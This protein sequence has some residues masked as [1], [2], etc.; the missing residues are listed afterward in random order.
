MT[1]APVP[2]PLWRVAGPLPRTVEVVAACGRCG[3]P[4]ADLRRRPKDDLLAL[5]RSTGTVA[6]QVS[7][8]AIWLLALSRR[9][10]A[11]YGLAAAAA[12][13]VTLI[14]A[15]RFGWRWRQSRST[16]RLTCEGASGGAHLAAAGRCGVGGAAVATNGATSIRADAVASAA[17]RWLLLA[18]L[19]APRA[20]PLSPRCP[21]SLAVP[22]PSSFA[23][24]WKSRLSRPT[25]VAEFILDV[26]PAHLAAVRGYAVL[27]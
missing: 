14:P 18:A 13:S 15:A 19:E 25:S 12:M 3:W 23:A 11:T 22:S 5:T 9:K 20:T 26:I 7:L 17:W 16:V 4:R 10:A 27:G 24:A 6:L 1:A 2:L 21:P 8:M